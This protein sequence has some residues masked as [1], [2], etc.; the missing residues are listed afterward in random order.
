MMTYFKNRG[1]KRN[2]KPLSNI[3]YK[4]KEPINGK[5]E[6]QYCYQK[7]SIFTLLGF[8]NFDDLKELFK[9]KIGIKQ[10]SKFRQGKRYFIVQR[11]I[12]NKNI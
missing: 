2:K 4:V 9:T 7:Q 5:F 1:V 10:W 6:V 11:R 8:Y 12:N 3:H